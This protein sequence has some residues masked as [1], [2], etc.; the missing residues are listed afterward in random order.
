MELLQR[1]VVTEYLRIRLLMAF[2]GFTFAHPAI[3]IFITI[4]PYFL[5][6]N[7]FI[8]NNKYMVLCS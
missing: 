2:L 5:D 1:Y 6:I 7:I 4:L 3:T 8:T